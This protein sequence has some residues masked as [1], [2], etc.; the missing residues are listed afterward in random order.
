MYR[1]IIHNENSEIL[2]K[3][4]IDVLI[5]YIDLGDPD[6]KREG[7]KQ[8][9]KDEDNQELKYCVRSILQNIPWIRKIFILMPNERVRYFKPQEEIKD[10]IVYVKDKDLIGF[11]SASSPVFQFNL[12]RMKDFGMSENLCGLMVKCEEVGVINGFI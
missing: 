9:K 8:I 7:I 1:E 11:D 10:K 6:L 5:K 12:W 3:E 4:P 2:E